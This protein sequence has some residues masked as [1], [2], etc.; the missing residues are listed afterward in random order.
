MHR[1]HLI[2]PPFPSFSETH[3]LTL[4]L[5]FACKFVNRV[6]ESIG[7]DRVVGDDAMKKVLHSLHS[8]EVALP[9]GTDVEESSL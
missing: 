4:W 5:L 8:M 6:L 7:P 3:T 9:D 2:L 1:P